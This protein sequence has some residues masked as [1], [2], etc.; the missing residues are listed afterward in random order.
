MK[1]MARTRKDIVERVQHNRERCGGFTIPAFTEAR[2][3]GKAI[4]KYASSSTLERKTPSATSRSSN[5]KK[6]SLL[7]TDYTRN[8]DRG[9]N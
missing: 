4:L 9:V 8:S 2:R 3:F 6:G 7:N 1:S 5:E